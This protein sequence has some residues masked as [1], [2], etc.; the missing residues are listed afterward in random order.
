MLSSN[1]LSLS[2][3]V[4]FEV[5]ANVT[6]PRGSLVVTP[7]TRNCFVFTIIGDD[8]REPNETFTI[9]LG[10]ANG[11]DQFDGSSD[12]TVVIIDDNDSKMIQLVC[13]TQLF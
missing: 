8:R 12:V 9:S 3:G 6:V 11:L 7:D 13:L 5:D 1:K 4:D 2:G 10:P